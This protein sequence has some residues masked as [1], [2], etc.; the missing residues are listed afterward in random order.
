MSIDKEMIMEHVRDHEETC[1]SQERLLGIQEMPKGYAL[2]I[3]PDRTHF[4]WLRHD[5]VE[6]AIHWDKWAVYRWAI[7]DS[8][9]AA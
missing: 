7:S 3:N 1:G 5:G 2:M 8:R 6:S 9:N 4:Y